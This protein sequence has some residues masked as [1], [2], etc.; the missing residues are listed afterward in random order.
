[1]SHSKETPRQKM[2][3]MMYLVLTCLLAINVSREVL[4]G[5]VTINEG[6][7]TTNSN[8]TTNTK[9]VMTAFE[10]AIQQG[11]HDCKPYFIKAKQVTALSQKTYDYV[12]NL[13]KEVVKFTEDKEGADTLKLNAADRLDDFDRPT[14]MLIGSDESKLK[15]G[16]HSAKE[17][18]QTIVTLTDSLTLMLEFMKDKDGLKL[19]EDDYFILKDKIRGFTPNDD[20]K[21]KEGKPLSWEMK[22]FNNMP[23]AAVVT[24]LSRIQSDIRRIE[25]EMVNSFAAASG[26][27]S[28]KFNQMQAR[29][30]PVSQYVQSG[31]PYTADVFL[32]ASSSDFKEDNLQFILGDVDTASGKI[33]AD[34]KVLPMDGGMGKITLPT[35]L[36]GRKN[37][38]GWIKFREGN[39]TYKYFKYENEYTVANPAVAVSPDKMNVFYAGVD[40]PIT[41]TAAGV[42][43]TE[44]VVSINGS[45]G[46]L[47]EIGNGKYVTRVSGT[48]TCAVSVFQKTAT[49]LKAQ[50][51]PQVFRVKRIPSP[52]IRINNYTSYDVFEI[53]LNEARNLTGISVDNRGFDFSASFKVT[54]FMLTTV[55]NGQGQEILCTGNQLSAAARQA[56]SKLRTGSKMYIEN[57]KVDAPDGPRTF[58]MVKVVVK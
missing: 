30:V 47:K 8:F 21:D 48:G 44:L 28:V 13:K 7:E 42:A 51:A 46:T 5:F 53:K 57:I 40:N 38:N 37:I 39:G 52:P 16:A 19:P 31:T 22:N 33:S 27:L 10:E 14:F 36:A 25:A 55:I 6:L 23:L 3:S 58:P 49:G 24:N 32:S 15:E 4:E 54:S 43:P 26:K 9:K 18:R 50:G 17:L 56:I 35:S 11:H 20:Y 41:V 45:N 2:I 1:M 12:E 29:I 34:A